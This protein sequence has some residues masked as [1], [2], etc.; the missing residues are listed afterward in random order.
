MISS[1][2]LVSTPT[3]E[4]KHTRPLPLSKAP[5]LEFGKSSDQQTQLPHNAPEQNPQQQQL[6]QHFGQVIGQQ[7]NQVSDNP[8]TVQQHKPL[9][10]T[11][12][13][14]EPLLELIDLDSTLNPSTKLHQHKPLALSSTNSNIQLTELH[15]HK[16]LALGEPSSSSLD[17]Q[18][19]TEHSTALLIDP[20]EQLTNILQN[21]LKTTSQ[22]NPLYWIENRLPSAA[23]QVASST[24]T[25]PNLAWQDSLWF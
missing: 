21:L 10:L 4:L 14:T 24:A 22:E 6:K 13:P 9:D 18:L 16:P 3:I 5:S 19:L 1:S 2:S 25:A 17:I 20:I 8:V 7:V 11:K 15:T 12:T 23:T